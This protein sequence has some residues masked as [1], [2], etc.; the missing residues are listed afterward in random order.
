MI[1]LLFILIPI[2]IVILLVLFVPTRNN[3]YYYASKKQ[4][5]DLLY[6]KNKYEVVKSKQLYD[7]FYKLKEMTFTVIS[8]SYMD[9][10]ISVID[11]I[12]IG[13]I[14]KKISKMQLDI[15]LMNI[16]KGE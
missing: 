4:Y 9:D 2:L 16:K 1:L 11:K 12:K 15:T 5:E 6:L 7:F 13:R 10:D 8:D 3:N 14:L